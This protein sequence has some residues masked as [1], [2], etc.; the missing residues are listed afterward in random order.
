LTKPAFLETHTDAA[1]YGYRPS[2]VLGLVGTIL[3][4]TSFWHI[5]SSPSGIAQG[6]SRHSLLEP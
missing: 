3:F 1:Q 4:A 5:L 2:L 6:I